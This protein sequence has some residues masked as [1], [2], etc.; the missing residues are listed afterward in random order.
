MNWL[1]E[2]VFHRRASAPIGV[3]GMG[4]VGKTTLLRAFFESIREPEP[5]SWLDLQASPD[6]FGDAKAFVEA[7][8]RD[9]RGSSYVVIDDADGLTAEQIEHLTRRAFNLKRIRALVFVARYLPPMGRGEILQLEP[10][11]VPTAAELLRRLRS[12]LSPEDAAIVAQTAEGNPLALRILVDLLDRHPAVDVGDLVR[13]QIYDLERRIILPSRQLVQQI[14]PAIIVANESLVE[15]LRKQPESIFDL[16]SR[17]FEELVAELLDGMGFEVEL[18]KETRDGGKDILAY[19]NTGIGKFLCLV[20]AKRYRRDRT[21]GVELVRTLY[22]TLCDYQANSAMLVTTSSF[23][24][25]AH[26]FQRK[27]EYQLALRDYGNVV[28]WIQGHG[29]RS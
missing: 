1:A 23:S 8:Y 10:L 5:V 2:L 18:T 27:H 3:I 20:E 12:T 24:T 16:P 14:K 21:I 17:R 4:G 6:P 25:D 29:Q 19:M 22:G 7:L 15:R 13:G 26:A 28:D 9:R 11:S